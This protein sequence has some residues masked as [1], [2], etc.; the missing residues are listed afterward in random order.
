MCAHMLRGA[1]NLGGN[2]IT[3][4]IEF[5]NAIVAYGWTLSRVLA[6]TITI[7][8][9]LG[10]VALNVNLFIHVPKGVFPA[11]GQWTPDE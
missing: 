9:L 3:P 2:R 4:P 10:T 1:W 8:V 7:L 5:F 11:A 6:L